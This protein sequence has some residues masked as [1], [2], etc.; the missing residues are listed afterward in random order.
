MLQSPSW[1]IA[2]LAHELIL[3]YAS[4]ASADRRLNH[5]VERFYLPP[6]FDML[7]GDVSGTSLILQSN[8][9]PPLL[10]IANHSVFFF[11]FASANTDP[12][13]AAHFPIFSRQ[14]ARRLRE[15]LGKYCGGA[16]ILPPIPNSSGQRWA[17]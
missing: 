6:G 11:W 2:V 15:W 14:V 16:A 12:L 13:S 9:C 17:S 8:I 10:R 5:S 3:P 1:D 7:L 4:D